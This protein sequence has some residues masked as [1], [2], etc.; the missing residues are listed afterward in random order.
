MLLKNKESEIY[1]PDGIQ[2]EEAL[3]RTTHLAVAAHQD[4]TEIMAF[5]GIVKCYRNKENWFTSIVTSDGGGSPRKGKFSSYTAKDMKE[6]RS[7]E[8]KIAAEIGGYSAQIL[9]KYTSDEVKN[10]L[11]FDLIEDLMNLFLETKPAIVYLHNPADK[12]DTHVATAIKAIKALRE[13]P[14]D[15]KP[16]K[17][18]GCEVWRDLDWLGDK[19]KSI[20][21]L[22]S[23]DKLALDLINVFESQISGGKRYDLGVIGR[24]KA[25]ATF[26]SSHSTDAA[27][28]I[29]FGV[30]LTPLIY[31]CSMSIKEFMDDL[32]NNF[33]T[34]V[35]DR[36]DRFL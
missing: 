5:D 25:H 11:N 27:T 6:L 8:Q 10:T 32:I 1:I 33:R 15:A 34:D 2:I 30:D 31:D 24:R 7:V 18:Y 17:V 12:H 23:D 21:D 28:S 14:D 36:I 35:R 3:K 29:A 16:K 19:D 20:F 9:L 4:D 26:S 13:I 22:G